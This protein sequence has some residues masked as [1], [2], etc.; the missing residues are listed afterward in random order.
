M[1]K[2]GA[3][4]LKNDVRVHVRFVVDT[5]VDNDAMRNVAVHS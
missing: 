5:S 2:S 3:L 4:R 1:E